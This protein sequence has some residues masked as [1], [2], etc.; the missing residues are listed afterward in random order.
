MLNSTSMYIYTSNRVV[1][2]RG[3]GDRQG[4]FDTPRDIPRSLYARGHLTVFV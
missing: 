4:G 2:S 3:T 1:A